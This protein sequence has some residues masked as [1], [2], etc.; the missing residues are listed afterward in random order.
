MKAVYLTTNNS[1]YHIDLEYSVE[2]VRELLT[3][4][5][6]EVPDCGHGCYELRWVETVHVT[7]DGHKSV[8]FFDEYVNTCAEGCVP[9][10]SFLPFFGNIIVL[11]DA[12]DIDG[13][14]CDVEV[15]GN[16]LHYVS[17]LTDKFM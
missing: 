16:L 10:N 11:G 3:K 15:N 8:V 17:T 5:M 9:H 14:Y 13:G 6:P 1:V 2:K 7:V 12:D 4:G